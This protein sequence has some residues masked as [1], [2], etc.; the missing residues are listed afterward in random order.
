MKYDT[1]NNIK[2][3]NSWK[4]KIFITFDTDWCIDEI[5][6]FVLGELEKRNVKATFFITHDTPLLNEIKAHGHECGI[7]PNFN[8]LLQGDFRYGSTMEEVIKYYKKLVPEAKS[9]RS[10]A[11]TVSYPM[12]DILKKYDLE[13]ESNFFIPIKSNIVNIPYKH[14]NDI[15]RIPYC[16]EDSTHLD[17]N[18]KWSVK[19]LLDYQ[20]IKVFNFHPSALFLNLCSTEHYQKAK[21]YLRDYDELEKY[22]NKDTYGTYDFFIDL[23]EG[24]DKYELSN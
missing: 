16:W 15:I 14:Y 13:F 24:I 2:L 11:L 17:Y 21:A 6:K 20:G 10:H 18:N 22:I 7:H 12:L 5:L 4:N 8:F 23:I 3:D 9:V 1:L 19:E